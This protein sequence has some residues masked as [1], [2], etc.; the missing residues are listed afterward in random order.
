[1]SGPNKKEDI[2][3]ASIKIFVE[4]GYD[5]P[6]MD[7]IAKNANV[8]KRTLYKHFPN[9]K[10]LLEELILRLIEQSISA[11]FVEYNSSISFENQVIQFIKNKLDQYLDP[12]GIK[13]SRIIL[14]ES[15]KESGF[16]KDRIENV[17]RMESSSL[18]WI[19][20]AQKNKHVPKNLD[21][22]QVLIFLNKLVRGLFF[23]P[24]LLENDFSYTD[25]D[26][27]LAAKSFICWCDNQKE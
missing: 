23:F 10:A 1:M 11:T 7:S 16:L 24:M 4:E 9:K 5:R 21:S 26:I 6:T 2:I 22:F 25:K 15:F 12:N 13:L 27:E 14:S 19:E 18:T 17:L 20:Q 8:S 3:E